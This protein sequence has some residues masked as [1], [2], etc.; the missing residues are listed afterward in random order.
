MKL[1]KDQAENKIR[2][3]FHEVQDHTASVIKEASQYTGLKIR[4][5]YN[6][7]SGYTTNPRPD[8]LRLLA[9]F[10]SVK[11]G[12]EVT[13]EDLINNRKTDNIE[14]LANSAFK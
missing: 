12:R 6:L 13:I 3:H 5:L 4:Q 14:C 9:A 2:L 10:F 1:S 8:N 7:Y 11:L